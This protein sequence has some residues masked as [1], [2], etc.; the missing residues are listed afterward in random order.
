MGGDPDSTGVKRLKLHVR[1]AVG[2]KK[3]GENVIANDYEV[4]V[5]A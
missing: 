3:N 2:P 5:A 4:A 1:D